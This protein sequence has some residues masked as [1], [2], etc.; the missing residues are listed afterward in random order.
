MAETSRKA[1]KPGEAGAYEPTPGIS[2]DLSTELK[3]MFR[4]RGWDADAFEVYGDITPT[5]ARSFFL[6]DFAEMNVNDF[7]K[8]LNA[9]QLDYNFDSTTV[10]KCP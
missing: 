1:R 3:A 8:C 6:G 7:F 10:M 2:Q 9:M 5:S 4:T